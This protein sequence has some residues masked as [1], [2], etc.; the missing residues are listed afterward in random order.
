MPTWDAP[1]QL[2]RSALDALA[3]HSQPI[4]QFS[5]SVSPVAGF[6]LGFQRLQQILMTLMS[7]QQQSK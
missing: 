1:R 5:F 2:E 7:A 3:F 6:Q 4:E